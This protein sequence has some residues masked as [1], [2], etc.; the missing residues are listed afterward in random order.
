MSY[1]A[2][3]LDIHIRRHVGCERMPHVLCAT[4]AG[5]RVA[6]A[7]LYTRDSLVDDAHMQHLD[8][9]QSLELD[10]R[11]AMWLHA[12][13]AGDQAAFA[14]FYDATSARAWALILRITRSPELAEEVMSEA[15]LQ[16]WQQA[17]RFDLERGAAL[18]WL[19]TIC[20][21]RA[22]DQL[23][24][25]DPA[26][27]HEDPTSLCEEDVF[28]DGGSVD[29]LHALDSASAIR[30]AVAQLGE[31][32]RQ[33]LTLAFFRGLSHQEI[34]GRTGMPLG[35]VKTLLRKSIQ[36]LKSRLARFAPAPERLS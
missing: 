15:Y 2:M 34:A 22:L 27:L 19:F 35:T 11:L 31:A 8:P 18:A 13:A 28:D 7:G 1:A 16:V 9:P 14:A 36:M 24:R 23:R 10:A 21:S 30:A 4:R 29:L 25:R 33:L 17:Q 12:V 5:F 3:P 32:E 6:R 20:R 26:E